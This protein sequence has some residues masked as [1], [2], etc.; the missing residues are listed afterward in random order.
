[1]YSAEEFTEFGY[2]KD[3]NNMFKYQM[4]EN[5]K[6][7]RYCLSGMAIIEASENKMQC[8]QISD[9][10][11]NLDDYAS[12]QESPFECKVHDGEGNAL[13]SFD[14]ACK[15][16][17]K[18]SDGTENILNSEY[19]ECSLME[20]KDASEPQDDGSSLPLFKPQNPKTPDFE[21]HKLFKY[22]GVVLIT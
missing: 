16:Y 17:Y 5:M 11:T 12:V 7:G 2:L 8:V 9:V 1:M 15:Y 14:E 18:A 13:D 3:P 6:Y 10:K 19:C 21:T 20:E 22:G 4:L